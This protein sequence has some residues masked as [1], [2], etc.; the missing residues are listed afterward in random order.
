[1]PRGIPSLGK[2]L[3]SERQPKVFRRK[4][5]KFSFIIPFMSTMLANW[6]TLLYI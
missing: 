6:A 2:D 4:T 1:M 3:K 5:V